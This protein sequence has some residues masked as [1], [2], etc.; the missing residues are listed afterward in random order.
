MFDFGFRPLLPEGRA[1]NIN[2]GAAAPRQSHQLRNV[3][4]RRTDRCRVPIQPCEKATSA[5]WIGSKSKPVHDPHRHLERRKYVHFCPKCPKTGDLRFFRTKQPFGAIALAAAPI[6]IGDDVFVEMGALVMRGL[7]RRGR[8]PQRRD[9]GRAE[10]SYGGGESRD[11][12]PRAVSG[13]RLSVGTLKPI[14]RLPW[15]FL[16][17]GPNAI[18]SF[19]LNQFQRYQ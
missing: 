13:S 2:A 12:R 5:G 1:E 9:A 17:R 14:L 18:S 4:H 7:R 15:I 16:R 8:A 6:L 19:L 10:S 11:G 3:L